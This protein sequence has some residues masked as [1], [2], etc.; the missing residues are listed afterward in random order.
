VAV[1]IPVLVWEEVEDR[2]PR[3]QREDALVGDLEVVV[4]DGLA[5][6]A[7]VDVAEDVEAGLDAPDLAEEVGAAEVE[8]AMVRLFGCGCS[9]LAECSVVLRVGGKGLQVGNG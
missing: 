9:C 6:R 1:E 5:A 8:I 4:V 3:G 2:A 7:P